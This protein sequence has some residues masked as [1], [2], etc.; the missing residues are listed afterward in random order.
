LKFIRLR[1]GFGRLHSTS[2]SIRHWLLLQSKYNA[3]W[4]RNVRLATWVR[5]P[6]NG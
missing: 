4:M 2:S 6:W 3:S 1:T 5:I